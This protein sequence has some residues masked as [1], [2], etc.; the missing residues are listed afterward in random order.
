MCNDGLNSNVCMYVHTHFSK[1]SHTYITDLLVN[2]IITSH[3]RATK[4]T[5]N[6]HLLLLSFRQNS[7]LRRHR[8]CH[9]PAVYK[10]KECGK[11][12]SHPSR[13]ALHMRMHEGRKFQCDV[14]GKLFTQKPHLNTHMLIHT[15]QKKFQCSECDKQFTHKG[16]LVAHSV[17]HTG[18]K[19]FE[20]EYCGKRFTQR[21]GL[22][23]HVHTHLGIKK[24]KCNVC[25]RKFTQKGALNIH[26]HIHSGR[27]FE[28]R[29]C[30]KQFKHKSTLRGHVVNQHDMKEGGRKSSNLTQDFCIKVHTEPE[31][32]LVD[33]NDTGNI[34]CKTEPVFENDVDD[35]DDPNFCCGECG[36]SHNTLSSLSEHMEK[37]SVMPDHFIRT[38]D[39]GALNENTS[40]GT[41]NNN[42]AVSVPKKNLKMYDCDK[43]G[44]RFSYKSTLATHQKVVHSNEKQFKCPECPKEFARKSYLDVH[45]VV[46]TGE[47][48]YKCDECG[49][50]FTQK[51]SL[52][53]HSMTHC[54]DS[55]H[56]VCSDCDVV[57]SKSSELCIHKRENHDVKIELQHNKYLSVSDEMMEDLCILVEIEPLDD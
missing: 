48:K 55:S 41:S 9:M 26:S 54:K 52:N 13:L 12:E 14:C 35:D 1:P 22:K 46:H 28:C 37:H 15:G 21:G 40:T 20:C 18:Q 25:D 27:K 49:K 51:G 11:Q 50:S 24:Y 47:K 3:Y 36:S 6:K 53:I 57:F 39:E 23:S 4:A 34:R 8:Q 43:C 2:I 44:K 10:C 30:G 29:E 5:S 7:C 56:L 31:D 17:V 45:M 33:N 16:T 42:T 32:I 38:I 19:P